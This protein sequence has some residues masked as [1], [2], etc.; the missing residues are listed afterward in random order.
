M[1][2]TVEQLLERI[3]KDYYYFKRVREEV[4]T[5][6]DF[7]KLALMK[8]IYT[9]LVLPEEEKNNKEIVQMVLDNAKYN[10]PLRE[11]RVQDEEQQETLK[12]LK[13]NRGYLSLF[14][15]LFIK[16]NEEEKDK[17]N[18][19]DICLKNID[20]NFI[21]QMD[22][23]IEG[24]DEVEVKYIKELYRLDGS[25]EQ[26]RHN[27]VLGYNIPAPYCVEVV[28]PKSIVNKAI[29]KI[30][31]NINNNQVIIGLKK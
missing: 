20:E 19:E 17:N 12:K 3:E 21:S 2:L 28:T 14:K 27:R 10:F 30:K 31:M 24:L 7:I 11:I 9:Y 16:E 4:R 6:P 29:K 8:N 1:K 22:T 18:I 26:I 25:S 15:K 23:L 5:N 13:R